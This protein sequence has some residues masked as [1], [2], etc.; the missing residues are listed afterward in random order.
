MSIPAPFGELVLTR[1][2]LLPLLLAGS[3]L[4]ICHA[5]D[6]WTGSWEIHRGNV[7]ELHDGGLIL[8]LQQK[9]D[10]VTGEYPLIKGRIEAKVVMDDGGERLKGR[11]FEGNLSGAFTLVRDENST[12]EGND[13]SGE[14]WTGVRISAHG[15]PLSSRLLSPRA[16]FR[17]FL[18]SGNL[19][20]DGHDENWLKALAAFDFRRVQSNLTGI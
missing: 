7:E 14:W 10:T 13:D 17:T 2:L 15:E 16:A 11:W 19:G 9:G 6:D 20:L 5:E 12:L 4:R 8:N 3:F 1:C 18:R